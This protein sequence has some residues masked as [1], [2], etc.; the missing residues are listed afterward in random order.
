MRW[1][2]SCQLFLPWTADLFASL[3]IPTKHTLMLMLLLDLVLRR[4]LTII[5]LV[6]LWVKS[7]LLFTMRSMLFS[8]DALD[9]NK[10]H[11]C[12]HLTTRSFDQRSSVCPD[13]S[14]WRP[15]VFSLLSNLLFITHPNF[16]LLSLYTWYIL[17]YWRC[18]IVTHL[19]SK[20]RH[21]RCH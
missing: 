6:G 17:K 14:P 2:F 8:D 12:D 15:V 21:T 16:Y 5:A 20:R 9:T 18:C 10:S 19:R 1:T 11:K 13:T 7:K 3:N 4:R